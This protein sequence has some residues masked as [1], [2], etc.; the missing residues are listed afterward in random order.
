MRL[1][2]DENLIRGAYYCCAEV[3]RNR[4]LSGQPV[5]AWLPTLYARLDAEVR[6]S[7]ARHEIGC[8]LRELEDEWI[9]TAEAAAIL[10]WSQRRVQRR[11][12]DLG[13]QV[14]SGRW[15]FRESLLKDRND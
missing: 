8:Q 5:P 12:T 10:G 4:R 13:G 14:V 15:L 6:V 2:D 3:L 11:A 1:T 9:G 7:R